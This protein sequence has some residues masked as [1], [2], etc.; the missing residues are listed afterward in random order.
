MKRKKRTETVARFRRRDAEAL[1]AP[2]RER[3]ERWAEAAVDTLREARP[4]LP[5][6]LE[7]RAQDAAEPLLAIADAA[8][9]EWPD[10]ARKALVSL[11]GED[12]G[13]DD[14]LGVR[15]LADV[16]AVFELLYRTDG[17]IPTATLLSELHA[18]EEA[19]WKKLHKGEP[20]D[21][22][23]LARLLKPFGVRPRVIRQ[24]E[25]TVRGYLVSAFSDPF[26]R[27]LPPGT[28]GETPETVKQSN[29]GAGENVSGGVKHDPKH[30]AAVL[31]LFGAPGSVSPSVSPQG[32]T[33]STNED[34]PCVTVSGVSGRAPDT[35][36]RKRS[37]GL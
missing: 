2:L 8:G 34:G 29:D 6:K 31:P 7:D 36:A 23:G 15:L 20:L 11:A 14:E 26:E 21:P 3:L 30:G 24:A 1:A 17:E 27:Y 9:A 10:V 12:D 22:N 18:R 28:S 13:D 35:S 25:G 16:R 32:E 5:E 19:P 33:V 4:N 37:F